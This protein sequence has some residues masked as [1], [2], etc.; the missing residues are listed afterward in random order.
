MAELKNRLNKAQALEKIRQEEFK[1]TTLS[2]YRYVH[3]DEPRE[4]RDTLFREWSELAV[5]GRTYLSQEG[6][7]AQICVPE[8]QWDSF[9]DRLNDHVEFTDMPFKIAVET[10]HESFWKLSIKVRHQIVADGLSQH[11]YD[12]T[13]VGRHLDPEAFNQALDEENSIVVDMRNH[14]ESRIGKFEK[15]LT[16]NADTFREELP[17]VKEMLTGKEDKKILLYCTGGIRCEKA[18]AYLKHHGFEDVNQLHGGIINYAHDM[19]RKGKKSRFIGKNFVFDDRGA[20]RITA[21]ILSNCDQCGETSDEYTNCENMICNLLF[22]QCHHCKR[23]MNGCCSLRCRQECLL[24]AE[25]QRRRRA[26]IKHSFS[27]YKAQVR[28]GLKPRQ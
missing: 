25:Q 24:P 13:N 8:P 5:L 10:P 16:P 6:I 11:E 7:N 23:K 14:Y 12:V 2:F 28:P 26:G 1:R 27:R 15:A 18:S 19:K 9:I 17:M 22:I 4:K 21:D 20:E 3:I